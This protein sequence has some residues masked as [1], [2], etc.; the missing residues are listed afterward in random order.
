MFRI[1][2]FK[3][4]LRRKWNWS[5]L[6][7]YDGSI[8]KSITEQEVIYVIYVDPETNLPVTKFF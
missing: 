7:L 6:L 8:D 2:F 3:K 1:T 5:I 4:T